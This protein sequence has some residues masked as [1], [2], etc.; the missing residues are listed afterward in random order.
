MFL[1]TTKFRV[2]QKRF[3]GNCPRIMRGFTIR[4]KR[5]NPRVH[6]FERPQNFGSEDDFQHFCRQLCLYFCFGSSHVVLLCH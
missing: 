4:L 2:A 1:S 6:D 5:L 3:G